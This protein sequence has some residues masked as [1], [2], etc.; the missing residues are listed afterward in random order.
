MLGFV[1]V[2]ER[3]TESAGGG[4]ELWLMCGGLGTQYVNIWKKTVPVRGNSKWEGPEAVS[5]S[6]RSSKE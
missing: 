3:G 2:G 5:N 4:M 1:G 6:S